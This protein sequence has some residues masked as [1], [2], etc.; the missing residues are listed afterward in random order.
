MSVVDDGTLDR[1]ATALYT[2]PEA[3]RYLDVP[4]STLNSWAHGYRNRP[5][6]RREVVGAPILTTVTRRAVRLPIIPFIGLAEGAV[7]TAIRRSGVPMQRIRPALEQLDAQIGLSHA[8]ASRRLYTDGAEILFD[9]AEMTEDPDLVRAARDLVV[10][11]NGQRVFNE[12]VAAYLRRLEFDEHGYV[13][14]I[15]LPAYEVAEIVVDP[16]RGFGQ[17]IFAHG[18]ARLDDALSLFR[19]GEPLNVVADEYGIPRD[20]LEDAVRIATRSAA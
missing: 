19:A 16:D 2:V 13:R 15:R 7:L 20:H 18:G 12:V 10:V 11:R 1:F 14:L 8:L 17:P 5:P 6:G 4:T 9:Y 3:A